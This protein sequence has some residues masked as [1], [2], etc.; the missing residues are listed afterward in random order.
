[1]PEI[2]LLQPQVLNGVIE[3][4]VAPE[5]YMGLGQVF[6]RKEPSMDAVARWDVIVGNREMATPNVPNSE[7]H[8][9]PHLGIGQQ[10]ATFIY[11]RE[12]K[13]FKPT[14]IRWLRAPGQM[15]AKN[16][17]QAVL[18]EVRDLDRRFDAFAEFCCWQ[19][20][21][22]S[23]VLNYPDVKATVDYGFANTHRPALVKGWNDPTKTPA[24]WV[25]DVQAWKRLIILDGRVPPT[26]V[27]L[28]GSTFNRVLQILANS[29]LIM[30]DRMKDQVLQQDM[31][32]GLVGLTWHIYDLQ[33]VNGAGT[34]VPFIADDAL[35]LT[36]SANG[37]FYLME[38]PSADED[39]PQG[40]TGKFVKSW[41]EPDPSARQHLEEWS[42]LPI[43]ERPEQVV[44]V[45]TVFV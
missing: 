36:S 42:F 12:K 18:R 2:S 33:F 41:K 26:D 30:S 40:H 14:T 20:L 22:G 27:W 6:T 4:F 23:I 21:T 44:Y 38:G 25:A 29:P 28:N 35:V 8:I 3:K 16:A 37:A 17:E 11:L 13:V 7:A 32:Q 43:I 15:A 5:N 19:S 1:M 39:A 10:T 9:V 24:Q 31:V 34:V 45:P